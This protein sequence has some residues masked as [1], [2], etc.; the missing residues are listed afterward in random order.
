MISSLKEIIKAYQNIVR[1][2]PNKKQ[3][4]INNK[5]FL[6]ETIGSIK[7]K[8]GFQ[9]SCSYLSI[10]THQYFAWKN[11]ID[12]TA[13]LLKLCRKRFSTQLTDKDVN[14][15]KL[16]MDNHDFLYLSRATIYWKIIRDGKTAFSKSTFYKYCRLLGYE[17]RQTSN[18]CKKNVEGIKSTKVAEILHTDITY[19]RIADGKVN[20]LS[21]VED[22]FSKFILLGKVTQHADSFFIKANIEAVAKQYGLDGQHFKWLT[23][24]KWGLSK[25]FL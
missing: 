23:S 19:V 25:K 12:C 1:S 22:N 7:D 2:A 16:Y 17:K 6:L 13:S 8:L 5:P 24:F 20:Y 4:L 3:L 21:F 9:K 15:I 10:T 18:K 14:S 11:N